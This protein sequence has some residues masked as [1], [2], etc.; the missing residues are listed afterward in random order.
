MKIILKKKPKKPIIIEGFPGFGLV[1]TIASEFLIDH[2]KTEQIG[3]IRISELPPMVAVHEGKVVDPIGI[4]YNKQYNIIIIHGVTGVAKLEW[5]ITDAIMKIANQLQAKELVSLEGIGSPVPTEKTK[6]YFYT[7]DAKRA[8]KLK[9]AGSEQLKEGIIMG[10]TGIMML[11]AEKG[12]PVTS[13]F[14]ET[15]SELPDSKAAA[16]VVEILSKYMGLKVDPK[17]LLKQA[18]KFETKLKELLSKS[19]GLAK[20]RK[21]KKLSYVG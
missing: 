2:L 17:P 16:K 6:T 15:H 8:K 4:F 1:G 19:Q 10:T 11:K 14:A 20:E 21:K 12:M 3:S 5:K 9:D 13:I 18:A 7:S